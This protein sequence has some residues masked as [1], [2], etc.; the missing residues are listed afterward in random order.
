MYREQDNLEKLQRKLN[1]R[2]YKNP[3]TV[4]RTDF[5]NTEHDV[6]E[7]WESDKDNIQDL[8]RERRVGH[9]ESKFFKKILI[10]SIVFFVLALI[11][12]GAI[13]FF[14]GNKVSTGNID[15]Q[16]FGPT[17]VAGG[18]EL[19]LEIIIKNK[20]N[21]DLESVTLLIEYPEGSRVAGN[22]NEPLLRQREILGGIPS[23]REVRKLVKS[24]LF[25]E[26][27]SIKDI[28]MTL[29]Y[30]VKNSS[31]IFYKEKNF[32]LAIKS[33]PVI[34]SAIYP[35]EVSSGQP[36]SFDLSID[37]NTGEL[38]QNLILKANYPFGF[39]FV[40]SNPKTLSQ[41]NVWSIGDLVSGDKR[42]I[43]IN[44]IL[45]G[46]DN[47]ERTFQFTL[48]AESD[49]NKGEI[50]AVFSNLAGTVRVKK[51]FL[52]LAVAL[53]GD[54][55][56]VHISRVGEEIPV[57]IVWTNNLSFPILNNQI[58]VKLSGSAFDRTAIRIPSSGFYR[59][60]DNTIVWDKGNTSE[61]S[62]IDPGQ[63][64]V[65]SFSLSSLPAF[66]QGVTNPQINIEISM[67][68]EQVLENN[69]PQKIV[70]VS[71]RTVKISSNLSTAS[72]AVYS[73]G[74]FGN[75]G[76]I[77]PK[78]DQTTTY[79]IVWSATNSVNDISNA[80]IKAT[81]P[82]YVSWLGNVS[83]ISEGVSFDPTSREV[84]WKLGNVKAGTGLY[85]PTREVAFQLGLEPSLSHVGS[86]PIILGPSTTSGND[87]FTG[88]TVSSTRG[89]ITTLIN[90]DPTFKEGDDIVIR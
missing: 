78:A 62:K 38:Q 64:G 72:R 51:S 54:Q 16:V 11:I 70:S 27:D 56:D 41:N 65:V 35:Q 28:K 59:S 45:E 73:I 42:T 86:A 81:L 26:K 21:V 6:R 90:T 43:K 74:P 67:T 83:P 89:F 10:G 37:S 52:D 12:A 32:E 63:K 17:S 18:E 39:T 31:A 3:N 50:G 14:G 49:E 66:A 80:T 8:I 9:E 76:P 22:I 85:S 47:E 71:N 79:T 40:S 20:N 7:G 33:A 53:A 58:T 87:D 75:F 82:S 34:V 23:N 55:S 2:N 61:F 24:V 29:E 15:I 44:G 1:S 77:P 69:I 13:F 68:G 88:K 57:S 36:I 60:S 46:Q 4:G 48:G 84:V 5:V 19:P 25:G 30:R